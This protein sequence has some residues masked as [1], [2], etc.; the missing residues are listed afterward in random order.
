MVSATNQRGIS[1]LRIY[2]L[3]TIQT[4][5][6]KIPPKDLYTPKICNDMNIYPEISFAAMLT[7]ENCFNIPFSALHTHILKMA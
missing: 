3:Q 7:N 5:S 1:F 6:A 2:I 4:S